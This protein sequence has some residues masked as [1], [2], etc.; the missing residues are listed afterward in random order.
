MYKE[1][2]I[3][4]GFICCRISDNYQ[5]IILAFSV[6]CAVN[7]FLLIVL[8][9]CNNTRTTLLN[10]DDRSL[11]SEGS[12]R[13]RHSNYKGLKRITFYVIERTL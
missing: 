13:M 12:I 10:I 5:S 4:D 2:Y 6:K 8:Y 11:V 3:Y 7:S 1:N 9:E